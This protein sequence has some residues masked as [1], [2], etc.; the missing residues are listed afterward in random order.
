MAT[1]RKVIFFDRHWNAFATWMASQFQIVSV[2]EVEGHN[3]DKNPRAFSYFMSQQAFL[4][5]YACLET[6][7]LFFL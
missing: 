5:T 3:Y 4:E 1:G 7:G 6:S 2:I